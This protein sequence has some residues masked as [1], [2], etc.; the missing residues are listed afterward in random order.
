MNAI[1]DAPRWV[2]FHCHLDLYKEHAALIGRCD[3]EKIATLGVTTTPKAYRRNVEMASA[4]EFVM[5]GLGLHPQLISERSGELS[6]FEKLLPEARFVGEIGLDAGSKFYS[7]FDEQ[8]RIF[9]YILRACDEQGGKVMSI[10]S[11]RCVSKVL[12]HLERCLLSGRCTPVMHWFTGTKSEANRASSL[13]CYFSVNAEMVASQKAQSLLRSLP[14]DRILTET[15]G[16]FVQRDGR[17]IIPSDI[18]NTVELLADLLGINVGQMASQ[19]LKNLA[20]LRGDKSHMHESQSR[21][22]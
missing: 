14:I 7:S 15:D 21:L 17:P 5:V 18:P 16:P 10:H 22:F 19:L 6:L 12:Q 20:T 4:S 11:V 2:D 9:E 13:G 8:I 1:P 3:E